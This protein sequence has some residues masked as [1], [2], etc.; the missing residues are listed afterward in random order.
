[1]ALLDEIGII[2]ADTHLPEPPDLWTSRLPA[3]WGDK[4]PHVRWDDASSKEMWY[5]GDRPLVP[6]A[7]FAHAGWAEPSPGFPPR[8]KDAD[9]VTWDAKLRLE[10]MDEYGVEV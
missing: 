2:D 4:I 10:R 8:W 6:V 9:P 3:K 1:M 5:I 7:K